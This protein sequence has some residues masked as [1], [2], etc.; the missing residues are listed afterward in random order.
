MENEGLPSSEDL[1][2]VAEEQRIIEATSEPTVTKVNNC[3]A[4][5]LPATRICQHC[6]QDFCS[7]HFCITHE[8]QTESQPLVDDE[9]VEHKGRRIRLIGEGW[10]NALLLIKD[11]SEEELELRI[12][13][14]QGLLN[15]AVRTADYAQIS[16]AAH[17]YE[18]DHRAHSRYVAAIK[19]RQKLEKQGQLRLNKKAH[20]PGTAQ[21]QA[22][23]AEVLSKTLGI[24]LDQAK[25][26][27]IILAAQKKS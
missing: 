19:R 17:E 14:L 7:Q 9:G 13:E 11:L 22:S 1:D 10:P 16:I 20:T 18:R 2:A 6:G 8:L 12:K 3:I 23:P 5:G 15:Q 27:L 4:C 21:A 26:M 25:A 24:P